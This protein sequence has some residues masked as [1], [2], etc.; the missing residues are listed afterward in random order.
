MA[1]LCAHDA[2]H[3]HT[4]QNQ[5][6]TH[7]VPFERKI[8]LHLASDSYKGGAES[9][10][11]NTIESSLDSKAFN[12]FVASCDVAPPC[13]I[14]PSQF[15]RL[16]DWE[17]YPKIR[18]A[19]KYIFNYTNYT[20]LKAF[21]FTHK[22]HIIH[23][24]NY[25][26][27]LSPSV[28]FALRAYKRAYPRTR[29]IYTEHGYAPCANG[30]LYNYAIQ[31]TCEYCIGR[32]KLAIMWKNCDR[33][34]RIYSI[35]KGIRTLFYQGI[36][37]NTKTLFDKVLCVGSFQLQKHLDDG[38]DRA[39]LQVLTNPIEMRFYNPLVKLSNKQD[40]LVFFGRLSAEKNIT[41]LIEAFANLIKKPNFAH[42]KLLI[43]GKGDDRA[44][45]ENLARRTMQASSYDFLGNLKPEEI[46]AIL[47]I[48]KLS[49]TP[50]LC[51]ETFGLSIVESMLAGCPALVS[52]L[53][54]LSITAKRFGGFS[55]NDLQSSL[56]ALLI[57][58]PRT[59]ALF[60]SKRTRAIKS[61]RQ[62]PYMQGLLDAYF[63]GGII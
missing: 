39:K 56:E 58:Y 45:C 5:T 24:Q 11:R 9:V 6:L 46:K 41:L 34:G 32:C 25:L 12:V 29:L 53:P 54:E 16:D 31:H 36:F 47:Q 27:R 37:L 30:G 18:G 22:P 26:S 10:F 51:Y 1:N 7:K 63:N 44:R 20:R 55:F 42:F 14:A 40:V 57:N 61:L 38:W 13:N 23:T 35:L 49:I 17:Q 3:S 21:L 50:S 8:L 62:K 2:R 59:F 28:L 15:L 33:R 60:T 19:F 43:I 52:N 4:W 48:A